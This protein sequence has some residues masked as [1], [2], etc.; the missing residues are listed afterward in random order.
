MDME[1]CLPSLTRFLHARCHG[2]EHLHGF[3]RVWLVCCRVHMHTI[4]VPLEQW[5][6]LSC[7]GIPVTWC[8][9]NMDQ[10]VTTLALSLPFFQYGTP[11]STGTDFTSS[12]WIVKSYWRWQ[13]NKLNEVIQLLLRLILEELHHNCIPVCFLNLKEWYHL[14]LG[15]SFYSSWIIP[16]PYFH[17][18]KK[19]EIIIILF[20]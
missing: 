11:T 17:C 20:V 13:E 1:N 14:S 6:C 4:S 8:F 12:L 5:P 9:V 7:S 16:H 18:R 3:P 15:N 19:K 10:C 2:F